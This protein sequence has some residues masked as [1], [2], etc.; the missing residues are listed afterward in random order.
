M[1]LIGTPQ[2]RRRFVGTRAS[3]DSTRASDATGAD[4][5]GLAVEAGSGEETGLA[6]Y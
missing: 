1:V 5:D 3:C 6:Q 4:G 2:V